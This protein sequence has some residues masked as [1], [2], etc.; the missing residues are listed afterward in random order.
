[1]IPTLNQA[2]NE[3][4][5]FF[6]GLKFRAGIR[7]R[8]IDNLGTQLGTISNVNAENALSTLLKI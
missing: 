7:I 8:D 5:Y 1:M 3:T 6:N 2:H 4:S